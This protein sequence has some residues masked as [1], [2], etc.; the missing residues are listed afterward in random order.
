MKKILFY[1]LAVCAAVLAGK[2]WAAN[3]SDPIDGVFRGLYGDTITIEVPSLV[4][5]SPDINEGQNGNLSFRIDTNTGYTN[6]NQ[7]TDLRNGDPI[8]IEYVKDAAGKTPNTMYAERI[9]KLGAEVVVNAGADNAAYT[10]QMPQP[11]Q[12]VTT[13]TRVNPQ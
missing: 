9:T 2:A 11:T 8:R 5:K 10:G 13:T 1:S 7:L 4:S 6:F 3:Y 12:T